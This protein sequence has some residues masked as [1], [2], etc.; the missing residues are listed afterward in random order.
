MKMG[1]SSAVVR[2]ISSSKDLCWTDQTRKGNGGKEMQR[3]FKN[4][5]KH[6]SIKD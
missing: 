6:G 2:F 3:A 1:I 5:T 4:K